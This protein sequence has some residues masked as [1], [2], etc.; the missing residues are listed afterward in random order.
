MLKGLELCWGAVRVAVSHAGVR[1]RH[2]PAGDKACCT[3]LQYA[4]SAPNTASMLMLLLVLLLVLR[5]L[6]L[7]LGSQKP[8][9]K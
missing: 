9:Y 2:V 1:S 8:F 4:Y 7:L 5:L 3:L 6:L